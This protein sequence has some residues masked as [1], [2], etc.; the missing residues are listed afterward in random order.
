MTDHIGG[1][2]RHSHHVPSHQFDAL[3]P[4]LLRR[5]EDKPVVVFHCALSQQRG[6]REA[7]REG[8][9]AAAEPA[10]HQEVFV[11][12]RGFAGWQE[13]YGP[14]EAL[15]EAWRKEIWEDGY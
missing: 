11:L 15:T 12:D 5:L 3:L 7:R 10:P 9:A 14:D 6:A 1:H 13:V 8:G 2:I 4:T